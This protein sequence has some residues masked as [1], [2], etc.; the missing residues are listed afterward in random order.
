MKIVI[1]CKI[2]NQ[3]AWEEMNFLKQ[4][5][6]N[7]DAVFIEEKYSVTRAN[8]AK[9]I[10]R[11]FWN[12]FRKLYY[13]Y[14]LIS[15]HVYYVDDLNSAKT[16]KKLEYLGP[17]IVILSAAPIIKKNILKVPKIGLLNAH[18]SL[19]PKYRGRGAIENALRAR[20]SVGVTIHWVDEGVDTGEII[21]QEKLKTSKNQSV[22]EIK[23]M[24]N[25]LSYVLMKK[26][27]EKIKNDF[28]R[29]N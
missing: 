7:I 24:A 12:I 1:F 22:K 16:Q 18:P 6:I 4:G 14:P 26:V 13:Y 5:G 27:I 25:R 21:F 28:Q 17:D 3:F 19:L 2:F 29:K 11:F 15:K 23:Q 10:F 20:D 8:F 9:K